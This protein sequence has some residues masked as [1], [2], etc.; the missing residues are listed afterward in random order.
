M[1]DSP[2]PSRER[3]YRL[4]QGVF[5]ADIAIGV[6]LMAGAEEIAP[7]VQGLSATGAGLALIGAC[8]FLLF[9]RLA[10]RAAQRR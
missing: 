5:V 2:D 10:R 8:L 9:R 3:L 6:V 4:I 7:G 1:A